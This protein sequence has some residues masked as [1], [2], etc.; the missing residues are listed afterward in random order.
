MP[1]LFPNRGRRTAE[2]ACHARVHAGAR[3]GAGAPFVFSTQARCSTVQLERLAAHAVEWM[4]L[5][6]RAA[7]VFTPVDHGLNVLTTAPVVASE[8]LPVNVHRLRDQYLAQAR[9]FDPFAPSRWNR[10][11]I[12]VV[13]ASDLGGPHAFARSSFGRFLAG[14]G[15]ATQVTVFF[16][17]RGRIVAAAL[18]W[19]LDG[20]PELTTAELRVLRQ[21]QP[22]LEQSLRLARLPRASWALDPG[23][24]GALTPRELDVARLAAAGAS[25]AEISRAL[26]LSIG[27]VKTH[28]S[29]VLAKLELR[30][31]TE[32]VARL[33]R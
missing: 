13:S 16:R 7:V 6:L 1:E 20:A 27:T 5:S 17:D 10:G 22:F 12:T 25:N 3:G 30:S 24:T 9:S 4:A 23:R 14:H 32:L 11:T 18:L 21:A 33:R 15:L 31:R 19:R 29:R 2:R 26:C 28:M 8:S